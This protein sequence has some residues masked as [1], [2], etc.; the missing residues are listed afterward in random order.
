MQHEG[1]KVSPHMRPAHCDPGSVLDLNLLNT[2]DSYFCL[3]KDAPSTT[4]YQ[5]CL[6]ALVLKLE[7]HQDLEGFLKQVPP[8]EVLIPEVCRSL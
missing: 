6:R 4:T 2:A 7:L 1:A 3:E 8:Q 5:C